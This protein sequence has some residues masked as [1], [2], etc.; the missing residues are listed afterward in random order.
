MSCP[1]IVLR[2][3]GNR[4]ISPSHQQDEE[5]PHIAS[6]KSLSR[7]KFKLGR[8]SCSQHAADRESRDFTSYVWSNLRRSLPFKRDL[9]MGCRPNNPQARRNRVVFHRRGS[10]DSTFPPIWKVAFISSVHMSQA[11]GTWFSNSNES[12]IFFSKEVSTREILPVFGL[13]DHTS[14]KGVTVEIPEAARWI[15]TLYDKEP[16]TS[17]DRANYLN[18]SNTCLR[19]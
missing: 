19:E 10:Y 15:D 18:S 14:I 12:N 8:R 2:P 17:K 16:H 4:W 7:K 11:V 13:F 9:P 6:S 3:F 1:T 5:L